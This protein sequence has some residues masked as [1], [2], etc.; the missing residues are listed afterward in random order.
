MTEMAILLLTAHLVADFVL[1]TDRLSPRMGKAGAFALH[2]GIVLA[3]SALAL[4]GGWAVAAGIAAAHA[5]IE[6]LRR[7]A[8]P[9]AARDSLWA[10]LAGQTLHLGTIT[11]AAALAPET[12]AA[13]LWSPLP[14][15]A[16]ISAIYLSGLVITTLGTAPLIR[17]LMEP[18]RGGAPQGSLEN[19]G[20]MIGLLERSLIFLMVAIGEPTG[21]GFLIAAKSILRFGAAANDT[22]T[23][24][25]IKAS[26]YVIIG[27]LFSFGLALFLASMTV[28]VLHMLDLVSAPKD[29]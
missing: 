23:T 8:L 22:D 5:A 14:P 25:K 6:A 3:L 7:W 10:Y 26:E 28:E 17:G 11:A 1:P 9:D 19:A 13:G 16:L 12:L 4:G 27:T 24:A 2:I 21:I 18:F 15:A 29:N 20:R